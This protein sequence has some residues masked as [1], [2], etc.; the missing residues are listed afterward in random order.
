MNGRIPKLNLVAS[1]LKEIQDHLNGAG[2]TYFEHMVR[3]L[4]YSFKM[5]AGGVCVAIHAIYPAVFQT[6][7]ST[8]I[9]KMH[10]DLQPHLAQ[11]KAKRDAEK[12][13]D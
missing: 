5:I 12:E 8:T 9:T 7:G 3:A 4:G 13:R 6:T 1:M 11:I 10:N 2:E